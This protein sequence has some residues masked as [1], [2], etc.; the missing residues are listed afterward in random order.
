MDEVPQESSCE[1][2]IEGVLTC[3]DL[4]H[5]PVHGGLECSLQSRDA[6][7]SL[8]CRASVR[9]E[10][11]PLPCRASVRGADELRVQVLALPVFYGHRSDSACGCALPC[12][13]HTPLG[14]VCRNVLCRSGYIHGWLTLR[15]AK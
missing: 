12:R 5:D 10:D 11:L 9:G 7:L 15:C 14:D 4:R 8:P 3:G 1:A 6:N 13:L 2:Y